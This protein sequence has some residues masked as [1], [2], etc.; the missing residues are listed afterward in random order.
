M[1]IVRKLAIHSTSI[2]RIPLIKADLRYNSHFYAQTNRDPIWAGI[3]P[4]NQV[5]VVFASYL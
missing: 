4:A 5:L 2:H 1:F 3:R